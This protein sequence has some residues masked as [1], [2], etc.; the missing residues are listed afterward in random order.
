[1]PHMNFFLTEEQAEKLEGVVAA[2]PLQVTRSQV[3]RYGL[4]LALKQLTT[5][6]A[7]V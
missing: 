6:E 7:S 5:Q 2:H 1:M 3:I 4:E